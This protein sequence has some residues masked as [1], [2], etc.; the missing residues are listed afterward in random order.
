MKQ[1]VITKKIALSLM[2][3]TFFLSASLAAENPVKKQEK[4]KQ[5]KL[6]SKQLAQIRS[7]TQRRRAEFFSKQS[8]KP[9]V[10]GKIKKDWNN[11]GDFTRH[12]AQSI[13]LFA[14]RACQ[15]KAQLDE[16][17]AALRE[18][19]QYHLDRP[20]TFF[21]IHS[22]PSACDALA[23]LYI[24]YGPRGTKAPGRLSPKT[25]AVLEK[26]MWQWANEK[27]DIDDAEL[28]QSQAWWIENSE[29]HHA[30][31]FSTCWAFT[32]IL[33]QVDGYK[34]KPFKDGHLP[35]EHHAAWTTY[36]KE[37]LRQRACKGMF[38]EINS[39]SYATATLKSMYN[40]YDFSKDPV[41][42][43][44][45]GQLIDLYWALW[46]QEQLDAVEGGAKARCYA[47]SALRGGGFMQSLAW[48]LIGEGNPEFVHSS[49]LPFVTS[50]W[51]VPDIVLQIAANTRTRGTYE[52]RQRRMGLA[53]KGYDRPNQYRLKTDFGGI[54]R[55][56][57]C[58]PDF[59]MG[60]LITEARPTEDWAA[61]SSQNRFSG[62][63][64]EG[65]RDA[66]V[67][68]APYNA[69]GKS[70]KNGFW[71]VQSKGTMISQQ[72]SRQIAGKGALQEWRVFFSTAGLSKPIQNGSW[73][74][75]EAKNAYVGVHVVQGDSSFE[76]V[77]FGRWL[78]C[79]DRMTPVIIEAGR[80]SDYADFSTFQKK[81][82]AQP[83]SLE[84]S[85]LSYKTL[86][87]DKLTFYADQS[88]LPKIN[89]VA[90]NLAPALVFDSPFVQSK[91]NS[92]V[93]TIKYGQD[94][95]TLNFNE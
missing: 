48:Y 42:K 27:A 92:G 5:Q 17:N 8:G 32:G 91:W 38:I 43:K 70:I 64:F 76:Q 30:Q 40:F 51:T 65:D 87:S 49:M 7:T 36:L 85:I 9:L 24:F 35:A 82:M 74:F 75:A 71:S 93:V 34:D 86:A 60:S 59:I 89:G 44:R 73:V 81:V 66:R 83:L 6:S 79:K 50:T 77:K 3:F 90:V 14:M 26:T 11:R 63:I 67:Y 31:H 10:R 72:L 19:C 23:R 25:C 68:P 54:L 41:L 12:Y 57:Y 46:A 94:Q 84:K 28:E 69:K 21:E 56:S 29:N 15:L 88:R 18:L 22:F 13:A 62:V 52:I 53:V 45:A 47:A 20:K 2:I 58:T 37:Y 95:R 39:P 55:Y 80:K 4:P 33:K 1:K 61:I 78:I 16:A